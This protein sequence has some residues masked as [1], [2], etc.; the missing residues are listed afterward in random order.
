VVNASQQS[1]AIENE[2]IDAG[3]PSNVSLNHL[4]TLLEQRFNISTKHR[5][6]P[7]ALM[8]LL[9]P[10]VRPF[11]ELSARM[12][13]LGLFRGGVHQA[14]ALTHPSPPLLRHDGSFDPA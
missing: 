12:V 2:V 3:G 6:V 9:P 5:H 7:V 4:V 13:T 10:V 1:S 11:N 14:D 8:R